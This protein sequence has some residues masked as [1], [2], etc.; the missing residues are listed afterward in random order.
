MVGDSTGTILDRL[1]WPS[2]TSGGPKAMLEDFLARA[3][4]LRDQ[5]AGISAVGVSIG[6]PMNALTGVILSP[7]HLP[8][9]DRVPLA[10]ILRRRLGLSVAVEHD[11]AACLLAEHLWGGA[12]GKTHAVYLTCGTGCG[13]GILM[14]GRVVRGPQGQTPEVGHIR[15][16]E[17]GPELFGKKGCV[18]SFCA[19][20]GI[21]LL[22]REMFPRHFRAPADTRRLHDLLKQGDRRARAVLMESAR[23]TGQL[24]ALL[25][26]IFS[27]QVILL[28]S[29]ARY[30]GGWWVQAIRQ[31]FRREALASNSL[32]T[33]IAAAS[34]AHNLQ[35][36]SAIAPCVHRG[37]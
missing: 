21:A 12:K 3:R 36:L 28:G 4:Q 33:R 13:A 26:D 20:E 8:G 11:A 32:H 19:G 24:C 18:E 23:R 30:F 37:L 5:H 14:D 10:S 1:Q 17:D 15:L 29:M 35:D 16:A 9:W 27:P 2:N 25:A 7:P 31:E 6:G 34:L 22:S